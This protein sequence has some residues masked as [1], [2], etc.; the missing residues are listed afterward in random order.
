MA[1]NTSVS[2]RVEAPASHVFQ[3]VSDLTRMGEWSPECKRV[4]W[5]GGATGTAVGARFK[6][7]NQRGPRKWSTKGKVVELDDG[8]IAF[9]IASVGGLPVARWRYTI[10]PDGDSACTVTETWEDLRGGAIRMLGRLV[11][12]VSDRKDHNTRGMEETLAR[13]KAAAEATG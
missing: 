6:G 3:M 12:G 5:L 11:T 13:V 1:D 7:H 4:E 2:T 9:D 10:A 8:R